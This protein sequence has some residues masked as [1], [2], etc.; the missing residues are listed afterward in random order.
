MELDLC[1]DEKQWFMSGTEYTV[2][3]LMKKNED[4]KKQLATALKDNEDLRYVL[5]SQHQ[6]YGLSPTSCG[7]MSRQTEVE[8]AHRDWMRPQEAE[9]EPAHRDWMPRISNVV[10]VPVYGDWARPQE[11][12]AVPVHRDLACRIVAVEVEPFPNLSETTYANDKLVW[13]EIAAKEK[14][15]KR[16]RELAEQFESDRLLAVAIAAAE[17]E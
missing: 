17:R 1:F 2:R 10:P 8:P 14:E 15:K 16:I 3:A 4:L 7:Y 9:V 11:A 13:E 5:K 6:Q 12:N